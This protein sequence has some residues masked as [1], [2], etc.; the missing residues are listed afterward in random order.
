[1]Q[2]DLRDLEV[3]WWLTL[4]CLDQKQ[5][6]Q[7]ILLPIQQKKNRINKLEVQCYFRDSRSLQL[8]FSTGKVSLRF[9]ICV[10]VV[11][12]LELNQGD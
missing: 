10:I 12:R 7:K 5:K 9:I 11:G 1:V 4:T 6:N 8:F 2:V 3:G